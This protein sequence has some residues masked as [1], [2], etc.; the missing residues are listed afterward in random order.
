M[1]GEMKP[2]ERQNI[3]VELHFVGN[4]RQPAERSHSVKNN[5]FLKIAVEEEKLKNFEKNNR[6]RLLEMVE[7]RSNAEED[8]YEV[9][10]VAIGV[11]PWWWWNGENVN[12]SDYSMGFVLHLP[13]T[14]GRQLGGSFLT[15]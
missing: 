14:D 2:L 11:S 5:Q 15:H 8:E 10:I 7:L 13:A 12:G 3:V 1:Q 6:T 4:I 9:R